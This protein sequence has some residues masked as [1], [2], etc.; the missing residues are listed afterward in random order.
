MILQAF[1]SKE[2]NRQR[3]AESVNKARA[4]RKGASI[5]DITYYFCKKKRHTTH[6]CAALKAK[7]E[8]EK[9]AESAKKTEGEKAAAVTEFAGQTQAPLL[10]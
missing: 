3:N 4:F 6:N 7:L 2:L 8:R 9:K 5:A 1:R 10:I